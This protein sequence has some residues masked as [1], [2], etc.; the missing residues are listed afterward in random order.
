MD[1]L[2]YKQA[3]DI[4]EHLLVSL[5]KS[6]VE[7][8]WSEPF[9]EYK[10]CEE[11]SA[12]FSIEE[13]HWSVKKFRNSETNWDIFECLE[14]SWNTKYMY[15]INDFFDMI[16][17]YIKWDVSAVLLVTPEKTVEWFAVLTKTTIN[18]IVE[19]EFNTR[20]NSYNKQ[21][22]ISLL[23][24]EYPFIGWQEVICLHQIYINKY[25]RW[26]NRAFNVLKKILTINE[27]YYNLPILLETR[28]DS[29]FYPITRYLWSQNL[30]DDKYWYVVQI[31]KNGLLFIKYLE[32]VLFEMKEKKLNV[33]FPF[34]EESKKNIEKNIHFLERKF[35]Y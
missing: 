7:C 21:E 29:R 2:S 4:P 9:S 34:R 13:V 16:K 33:F 22:L 24:N 14:C 12:I 8:W 25:F 27:L 28:Y 20:P 17:E 26:N 31:I 11:C 15:K 23:L 5:A 3:K 18:W 30:I 6:E 1:I 10:I 35:Y 32:K 19:N